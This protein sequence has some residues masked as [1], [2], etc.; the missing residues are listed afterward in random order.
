MICGVIDVVVR[1]LIARPLELFF[2][3]RYGSEVLGVHTLV[4]YT[5]CEVLIVVHAH[6]PVYSFRS[7]AVAVLHVRGVVVPTRWNLE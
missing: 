3:V 6:A 1:V 7:L 4:V 5:C 2:I